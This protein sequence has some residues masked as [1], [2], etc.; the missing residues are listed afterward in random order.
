MSENHPKKL[1]AAL[2]AA[3]VDA[4]QIAGSTGPQKKEYAVAAMRS[5]AVHS[6]SFED[7]LLVS[8]L[9]PHFVEIVVAATK[10]L[11]D[12]NIVEKGEP[13]QHCCALL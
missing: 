3:M 8:E 9:A 1:I 4:E 11:V 6:L 5:L 12:I 10:G 13:S 7:A 2:V